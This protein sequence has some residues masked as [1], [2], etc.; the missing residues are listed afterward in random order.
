VTHHRSPLPLAPGSGKGSAGESSCPAPTDVERGTKVLTIGLT[1]GIGSGKSSVTQV[2]RELGAHVID[3][4]R[5]GHEVYRPGSAGWSAVAE[6]FGPEIVAA[7]GTIDRTKLGRRVFSDPAALK[8]L[9][10]LVH[11]LIAD[12]VR[13]QIDELRSR[14]LGAPVVVEAAVLLEARWDELVDEV[15]VV[16]ATPELAVDR[17]VRDRGLRAEEVERRIL[18][19]LTDEERLAAADCIIRNTGSL[20]ELRSEVERT[21][22]ARCGS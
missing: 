6:A 15:W 2:L 8:R 21:W 17:V 18:S 3:A 5:I 16:V 20:G 13:R 9:N 10:A 19:Q 22:A 12:E 14:G 7:D 11:P 4:D 1:G